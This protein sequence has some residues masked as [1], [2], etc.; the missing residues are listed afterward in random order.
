MNFCEQVSASGLIFKDA[1]DEFEGVLGEDEARPESLFGNVEDQDLNNVRFAAAICLIASQADTLLADQ[2][3]D[4][5]YC[6]SIS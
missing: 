4:R 1:K 3:R 2:R 5:C 6:F